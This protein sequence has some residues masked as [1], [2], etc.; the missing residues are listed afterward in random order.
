MASL[1]VVLTLLLGVVG[2]VLVKRQEP[3]TKNATKKEPETRPDAGGWNGTSS[4]V[5]EAGQM[6]AEGD[7]DM[8]E[9]ALALKKAGL[10]GWLYKDTL[11]VLC[12]CQERVFTLEAGTDD[13]HPDITVF[14]KTQADQDTFAEL[15]K[16]AVKEYA[17]R[18]ELDLEKATAMHSCTCHPKSE[19]KMQ[20]YMECPDVLN[21]MNGSWVHHD[22]ILKTGLMCDQGPFLESTL[23]LAIIKSTGQLPLHERDQISPVSCEK[24]GFPKVAPYIDH[25]FQGLHMWHKTDPIE[26]DEGILRAT[27]VEEELFD[28]NYTRTMSFGKFVLDRHVNGNVL[29]REPGCHCSPESGIAKTKFLYKTLFK[30]NCDPEK[31][32]TSPI[33]S[34]FVE[35]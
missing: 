15:K 21:G 23:A 9:S 13:C 25:C 19:L 1:S 29:N 17:D 24:L 10:Q 7:A 34:W 5:A 14:Y 30:V 27:I 6:C 32:A 18:W 20:A 26:E 2:A 31:K 22:P 3:A 11:A 28:W 35:K 12:G 33:R 4:F 16:L 8:V